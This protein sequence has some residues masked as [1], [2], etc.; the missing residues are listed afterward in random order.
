[1][2]N[3]AALSGSWPDVATGLG[4]HVRKQLKFAV[5]ATAD[6]GTDEIDRD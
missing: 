2:N 1:M 5:P 6:S 4:Y 3:G